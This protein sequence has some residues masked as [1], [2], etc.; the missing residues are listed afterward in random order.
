MCNLF[1][2]PASVTVIRLF[3]LALAIPSVAVAQEA[4]EQDFL[5]LAEADGAIVATGEDGTI[6]RSTDGGQTFAT[7]FSA[8]GATD[9]YAAVA[10]SGSTFV[11]VGTDGIIARSTNAGAGWSEISSANRPDFL[12]GDLLGVATDGS[13]NWVAVGNNAIESA[14][15]V[16]GDDGATWSEAADIPLGL[17][18]A[19]TWD[20]SASLWIAAGGDG[21]FEG[22]LHTSADADQWMEIALPANVAPLNAVATDGDGNIIAVGEQGSIVKSGDGGSSFQR[23]AA[24]LVTED[25]LAVAAVGANDFL[26]GG[27]Q[28]ILLSSDGGGTSIDQQPTPGSA[29]ILSIVNTPT[30]VLLVG[31]L[32][33]ALSEFD[34]VITGLNADAGLMSLRL[35]GPTEGT[36]YQIYGT[37]DLTAG[38]SALPDTQQTA[39]SGPLFWSV[40]F[41]GDQ[42]FVYAAEVLIVSD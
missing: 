24:G 7:V 25:L 15:F 19:V 35:D 41:T 5:A 16:S 32:A 26:I 27:V 29:D 6:A 11:A 30:G 33:P 42:F 37:T 31:E 2:A 3:W 4:L 34:L 17:L 8:G 21:F 39:G 36:S 1:K 28:R 20:A 23:I 10:G 38:F 9:R 12:L 18:N 22:R 40:A 14:I 13:G